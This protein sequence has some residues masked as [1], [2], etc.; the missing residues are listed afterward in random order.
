MNVFKE[1]RES[2]KW[3]QKYMSEEIGIPIR[4]IQDWESERRTP[5]EWQKRL[6]IKELMEFKME[7]IEEIKVFK[8]LD[9]IVKDHKISFVNGIETVEELKDEKYDIDVSNAILEMFSS[10]EVCY[11]REVSSLDEIE[12]AIQYFKTY[13][14]ERDDV[15]F[16]EIQLLF[17]D[18]PR[19][20][21]KTESI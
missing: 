15:E 2:L 16:E 14:I 8:E 13:K 1:A 18:T 21:Y 4:T 9:R 6:V 11:Y 12:R 3:T 7:K 19:D 5:P 17:G 20:V 10:N